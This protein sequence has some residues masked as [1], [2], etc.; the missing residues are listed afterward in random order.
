MK[1]LKFKIRCSANSNIMGENGLTDN[2]LNKIVE[3][4]HKTKLTDKQ[5]ETLNDLVYR[6]DNPELPQGAKTYCEDWL[7]GQLY[8]YRKMMSNKYLEKTIIAKTNARPAEQA[9]NIFENS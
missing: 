9:T 2:Q 7:K 4:Q 6:R 8:D 3:L 5:Q 1:N